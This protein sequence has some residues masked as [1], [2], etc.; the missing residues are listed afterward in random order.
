MKNEFGEDL[1]R[2]GYAPSILSD[3]TTRCFLCG[4][5]DR[6]IDRHEVFPGPLRTKCKRLGIWACLCQECHT[7]RHGVHHDSKKAS[8]LKTTAQTQAMIAYG[9]SMDDWHRE[10]GKNFMDE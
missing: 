5:R 8:V 3:D 9:W 1:D 2:N 4:R 7:G 10:F 6:K